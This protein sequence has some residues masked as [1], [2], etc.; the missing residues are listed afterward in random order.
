MKINEFKYD[1][2]WQETKV[3]DMRI[4]AKNKDK[5]THISWSAKGKNFIHQQTIESTFNLVV[6]QSFTLY[7]YRHS[8]FYVLSLFIHSF[9]HL[10]I[11]EFLIWFYF[12][13]FRYFLFYFVLI[14]L[15]FCFLIYFLL[16]YF[17]LFLFYVY[18]YF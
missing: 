18:F 14:Y 9:I 13:L 4:W 10:F 8:W 17:I 6:A 11:F 12:V 5:Q 3:Q 1:F 15:I 2:S 7:G 16:S